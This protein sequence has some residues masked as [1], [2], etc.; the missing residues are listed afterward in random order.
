MVEI[1]LYVLM[2]LDHCEL[3]IYLSSYLFDARKECI[4]LNLSVTTLVCRVFNRTH[5]YVLSLP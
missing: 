5:Q 1:M 4:L 3:T 2:D